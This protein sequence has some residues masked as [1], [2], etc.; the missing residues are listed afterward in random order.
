VN[1]LDIAE[2]KEQRDD[3]IRRVSEHAKEEFRFHAEA[4]IRRAAERHRELIV[5][6]VWEEFPTEITTHD[7]RAMGPVMK[8]AQRQGW[9][10]PTD[11]IRSSA[12][13]TCHANPR[14]IWLSTIYHGSACL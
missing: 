2:A 10:V 3:G 12:R 9:I 6:S 8:W 11:R 5:D 13:V 4:A 1:L 7:Y 14:R